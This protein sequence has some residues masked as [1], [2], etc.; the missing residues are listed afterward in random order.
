MNIY[1]NDQKLSGKKNKKFSALKRRV[2]AK[3]KLI[4]LRKKRK[5]SKEKS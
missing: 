2:K 3:L 4:T 1:A 5:K